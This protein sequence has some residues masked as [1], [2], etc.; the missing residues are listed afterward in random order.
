[1]SSI[2]IDELSFSYDHATELFRGISMEF[3]PG[4]TGVVGANGSGK[5]TLLALIAGRLLP[6]RGFIH[7]RP[8]SMVC[9]T[10]EQRC[11]V[12]SAEIQAFAE[13]WERDACRL[14][15]RLSLEST[16]LDRWS[17]LS[18]GQQ[19]RWQLSAAIASQPDVLLL[20]EP[21]NHVDESARKL[22]AQALARYRGIGIVVSHDRALLDQFV[23][24]IIM[25]D[26]S[27]AHT[28]RSNY[29][30]AYEL[31]RAAMQQKRDEHARVRAEE[32]AST[33]RLADKRRARASAE[34]RI[35][36]RR[37]S[38]GIRD[39]DARSAAAKV[40]AQVGEARVARSVAVARGRVKR[41]R[42][43]LDTM[44]IERERGRS[45]FVDYES[46]PKPWLANLELAELRAGHTRLAENLRVAIARDSRIRLA[47]DNGT[48]KTTLLKLLLRAANI[49]DERILY[50]P[51]ALSADAGAHIRNEILA[52]P[53]PSRSRAMH[54][55]AALGLDPKR[56]LGRHA[57]SPGETRK[58]L[59]ARGLSQQV[60]LILLDEPTN[61]LDLPSIERLEQALFD[62]PGA[63]LLVSHDNRF[64][65]RLTTIRW[66]LT[67]GLL[68][69]S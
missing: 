9:H 51:Q 11:D 61:H 6:E 67:D 33:R 2:H 29:S 58:L 64:A 24:R 18:K 14:R 31:R 26:S 30:K 35:G 39:S 59:F 25:L 23:D 43:I 28:Y 45:L 52:L 22:I 50:I 38:K 69:I 65:E 42:E 8:A 27:G 47:G 16:H 19:K 21:T 62:Y 57:P 40:R 3:E 1:M 20:D 7:R 66:T 60:W 32:R 68:H 41:V 44:V 13:S 56:V 10:C 53:A 4:W 46:S 5:S 36:V 34:S 48:G 55:A 15:A 37:R 63:L 49:P 54:I 12:L 17:S